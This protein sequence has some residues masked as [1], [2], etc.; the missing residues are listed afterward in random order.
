[1]SEEDSTSSMDLLHTL[2]PFLIG[3]VLVSVL[4]VIALMRF[5]PGVGA[6]GSVASFDVIKY[7]NAQR[8]VASSFLGKNADI[9]GTN[10]ILLNMPARTREA[11]A[12]VAGPGTLVVIKQ[13]V[14]QGQ[15]AD[16]TDEVL[17]K[18][19]LPTN[20]PTA[21]ATAY[22]MDNYAPTMLMG[23]GALPPPRPATMPQGNQAL[24]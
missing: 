13:A 8:A 16:I 14:V 19:G 9:G 10:E 1:M 18:L 11:I 21:D 23:G 2:A 3:T 12:S 5:M 17:T 15:T 7:T 4:V 6:G 24:P 22:V 20:V